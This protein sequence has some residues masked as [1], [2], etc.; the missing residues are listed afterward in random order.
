MFHLIFILLMK[1][2]F[3]NQTP[4]CI[5]GEVKTDNPT[6][7]TAGPALLKVSGI[8]DGPWETADP[9]LFCVYH[10]DDYPKGDGQ[11]RAPRKGDGSDFNPSAPYRMYHGDRIPGFPQ[12]PHRGFETVTVTTQGIIDHSD[13]MGNGGRYG[14]GDVQWM[15]AGKGIVHGEMFPLV[16]TDKPNPLTLFQIWLNLPKKDK[17]TDPNFVM[18]WHENIPKINSDDGKTQVTVWAGEIMGARALPPPPKSWAADTNN[19]VLI[20]NLAIQPSSS[21]TLPPNNSGI[22]RQAYFY[23]GKSIEVD[24]KKVVVKS[25]MELKPDVPATFTNTDAATVANILILQGRPIN[26]PVVQHGPFVMNTKQEIQQAFTDYQMTQFG[27]WPYDQDAVVFH[28]ETRFARFNGKKER[29]PS[30]TSSSEKKEM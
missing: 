28:G 25:K 22:N 15:T 16:N 11:G 17:M 12:H 13:S 20:V 21:F 10:R 30:S 2:G 6:Q 1:T 24:G 29:P 3:L 8:A 23:E 19:Q 26:E 14:H 9:F 4:N 27:G 5:A 18:H 7:V